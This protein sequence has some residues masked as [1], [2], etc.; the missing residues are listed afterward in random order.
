MIEFIN[1]S[2]QNFFLY[3]NVPTTFILND[4]K[5]TLIFGTNGVGK[6][7]IIDGIC[8]ALFGAAFRKVNKGDVV[9]TINGNKCLVTCEFKKGTSI[10]RVERG[11]KPTIFNVFK[12]GELIPQSAA[13]KDYQKML[14]E[15]ILDFNYKTFTQIC[16]LSSA[17]FVPFMQLAAGARREV[18]EDLLDIK[19]FASMSAI[20]KKKASDVHTAITETEWALDTKSNKIVT[21]KSFI[22]KIKEEE[23]NKDSALDEKIG[24]LLDKITEIESSITAAHDRKTELYTSIGDAPEIAAKKAQ[25]ASSMQKMHSAKSV[26]VS[27]HTFLTK[28]DTCPTCSQTIDLQFKSEKLSILQENIDKRDAALETAANV[29]KQYDDRQKEIDLIL[30]KLKEIDRLIQ[31]HNQEIDQCK[32][33]I[34]YL[35]AEKSKSLVSVEK[36]AGEIVTLSGEYK[37]LVK[38]RDALL[39]ERAYLDIM[40]V[41]LKDTGIKSTI[42]KQYVPILNHFINYY[43]ETMDFFARFS[44]DENLNERILIRQRDPL[45]YYGLSEGQKKRVDLAILFA[46]RA[47]ANAKNVCNTNILILDEILDNGLDDDGLDAVMSILDTFENKNLFI[48]SPRPK[49]VD[50]F[51]RQLRVTNVNN[52]SHVE[53]VAF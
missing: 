22:K 27:E 44:F 43:L 34:N 6:S 24:V 12:D 11:I 28:S 50:I 16:I 30:S 37:D 5:S 32:R 7:T 33:E 10:Y 36:E 39:D 51:D 53:E 14:E 42:V 25:V 15:N 49:V 17:S 4:I 31:S 52:Y 1:V 8:F 47:V 38:A 20:A 40:Q 19:V 9:N 2:M 29:I 46:F 23:K 48:I 35:T 41:M 13:S 3:G 18:I 45:S 21:L 26:F